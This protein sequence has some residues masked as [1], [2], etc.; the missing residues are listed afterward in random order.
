MA[1]KKHSNL[2]RN[3]GTGNAGEGKAT[4]HQ[5]F[6]QKSQGSAN[7][8]LTYTSPSSKP[9]SR[10]NVKSG[11]EDSVSTTAAT[12]TQ[13]ATHLTKFEKFITNL[14]D[15]GLSSEEIEDE[16][17]E[18]LGD[19]ID[20]LIKEEFSFQ[21]YTRGLSKCEI[22]ARNEDKE[23]P[24]V[25]AEIRPVAIFRGVEYPL[26]AQISGI[27][28]F[29]F[30]DGTACIDDVNTGNTTKWAINIGDA[31]YQK[32]CSDIEIAIADLFDL[33]TDTIESSYEFMDI[34]NL[35]VGC[36]EHVIGDELRA[37][38]EKNIEAAGKAA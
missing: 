6:F 27:L 18:R 30:N 16:V 38:I 37:T 25:F 9:E 11:Q 2:H 24:S 10:K 15:R 31:G 36:I 12:V 26:V 22:I 19:F 14:I 8:T 3:I 1:S 29:F 20:E 33:K 5:E 7:K 21:P 32:L 23:S 35:F 28:C 17:A 4:R 13:N 34:I